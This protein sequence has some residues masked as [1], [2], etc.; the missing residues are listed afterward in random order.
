MKKKQ[1][2]TSK[3]NFILNYMKSLSLIVEYLALKPVI[4]K[5]RPQNQS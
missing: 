4:L 5:L 1:G 3:W 2:G